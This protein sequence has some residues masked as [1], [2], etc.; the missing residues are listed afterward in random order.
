MIVKKRIRFYNWLIDTFISLLTFLILIKLIF[1]LKPGEEITRLFKYYFI[2]LNAIYYF[3]AE[4][5]FNRTIGKVFTKTKV[6]Y[7]N[8]NTHL[9]GKVLIRTISRYIPFE[10][11]S[12]F[13]SKKNRVLH[14]ML[15]NTRVIS[16]TTI[17]NSQS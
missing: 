1:P 16:N 10:A 7:P 8:D 5:F 4:L 13:L 14:D 11:L 3:V 12:I 15:S 6:E 17:N 9:L 2:I